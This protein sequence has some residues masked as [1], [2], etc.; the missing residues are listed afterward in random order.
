M[1]G[2]IT[3]TANFIPVTPICVDDDNDG[4]AQ[5]GPDPLEYP[6][7]EGTEV[8]DCDDTQASIYP[9]ATEIPGDGIDQNCDGI[10]PVNPADPNPDKDSIPI[11]EDN[12]PTVY[13]PPSD[14]DENPATPDEQCDSD[15]DGLGDAC[16]F[17]TNVDVTLADPLVSEGDPICATAIL[18]WA[19]PVGAQIIIP[20]RFN[21]SFTVMKD[22]NEVAPSVILVPPLI[23]IPGDVYEITQADV[24]AGGYTVTVENCDISRLYPNLTSGVYEI[25]AKYTNERSDPDWVDGFCTSYPDPC[26]DIWLGSVHS[27]TDQLTVVRSDD[28]DPVDDNVD[29]CPG[30]DNPDQADSDGDG[31]G[32][33]CDLDNATN[34]YVLPIVSAGGV[35]TATATFYWGG[36]DGAQIIEPTCYNTSFI[37]KNA[38]GEIIPPTIELIPPL[39]AIPDDVITVDIGYT[40]TLTCD[41][42]RRYP[43][44]AAGDY[45]ITAQYAN[46]ATDPD[47]IGT[48]CLSLP[49]APCI[50]GIFNWFGRIRR[51][52]IIPYGKPNRNPYSSGRSS[53]CGLRGPSRLQ[54]GRDWQHGNQDL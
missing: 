4:Y 35:I 26:L 38:L 1:N 46:F 22:G 29:N 15:G 40:K 20:T 21:T 23:D 32:D 53:Y 12:C 45:L 43:N 34:E 36:P 7:C 27:P 33:A 30:V 31:L 2:D 11:A 41:V 44:L 37:I 9:G 51:H 50:P 6:L 5:E 47:L 19:G 18:H 25:A 49:E 10:D 28:G 3:C 24:T 48:Q 39:I 16:D 13:N 52:D 8:Y 14:C 17:G 54:Q 42:S